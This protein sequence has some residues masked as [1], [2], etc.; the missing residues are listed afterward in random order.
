[1]DYEVIVNLLTEIRD[2]QQKQLQHQQE[3]LALQKEQFELVQ[4]QYKKAEKLQDR[5]ESLQEK[6]HAMMGVARKALAIILP[7][8]I[9]LVIYLS[10][11]ILTT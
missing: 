5:A 10:W 9:V 11:L 1:M 3:A 7:I 2:N 4:I 8:V 6:G